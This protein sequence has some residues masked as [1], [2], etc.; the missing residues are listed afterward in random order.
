MIDLK[1]RIVIIG[2]GPAGLAAAE[3]LKD[4]GYQNVTVLEKES[5]AGGK[6][7]TIWYEGRSYEMG[8]GVIV[9]NNHLI[10]KLAAKYGVEVKRIDFSRPILFWD[11][12][13]GRALS[14]PDWREKIAFAREVFLTYRRATKRYAK[15]A[16]TGLLEVDPELAKPFS[17]WAAENKIPLIAKSF[18]P[19]FTGFGYGYFEEIPAAYVLKYYSWAMLK[20]FMRK[21]VYA[22]PKG[23]QS[24]WSE[25]AKHHHVLYNVKVESIERGEFVRVKTNQGQ[26]EFDQL[27][28]AGTFANT[29]D[30]LDLDEQERLMIG[31]FKYYDYR[32]YACV[33]KGIPK[34]D[35]YVPGN[36]QASR[37]GHPIFWYH[38]YVDSDVY[39]FYVLADGV[40]NDDQVLENI[41]FVVKQLGGEIES[42]ETQSHWKYFPHV[43]E[44]RMRDGYFDKFDELQGRKNTYFVGESLNF[45]T[46]ELSAAQA[47]QTIE[48]FF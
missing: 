11:S 41:G 19:F 2:A 20:S 12:E 21:Q 4:K 38:R 24:L 28:V 47:V 44:E 39:T 45:A 48:R 10:R 43:R 3:A 14:E 25:V 7:H 16:E 29:L 22:F 5:E 23:I 6:C 35:G 1:K 17:K 26:M 18:G 42:V 13:E 27:I 30:Y 37:A 32:T 15:I 46:V 33:V 31:E 8:A 34:S 9:A 40:M 36:F